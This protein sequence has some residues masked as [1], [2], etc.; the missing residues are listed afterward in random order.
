[1]V[2][3]EGVQAW[4]VGKGI[5]RNRAR[6]RVLVQID[7]IELRVVLEQGSWEGARDGIVDELK[8]SEGG[9]GGDNG[10]EGNGNGT[11]RDPDTLND[12]QIEDTV[13][14]RVHL[15]TSKDEQLGK[16]GV[17]RKAGGDGGSA[18]VGERQGDV[19]SAR[20]VHRQL[21]EAIGKHSHLVETIEGDARDASQPHVEPGVF[22]DQFGV[23]EGQGRQ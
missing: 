5:V 2:D 6:E 14:E 9:H 10:R 18:H 7:L 15:N 13:G 21:A 4:V 16:V 23:G 20:W 3:G 12:R 17:L 22:E 8:D 19:R 1:V 11:I